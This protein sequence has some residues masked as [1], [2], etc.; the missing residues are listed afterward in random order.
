EDQVG[1][2]SGDQKPPATGRW[3]RAT[4]CG[5]RA[6][7]RQMADVRD[8]RNPYV[9]DDHRQSVDAGDD[10][11]GESERRV[12]GGIWSPVT[13]RETLTQSRSSGSRQGE[14]N[15]EF[16]PVNAGP[17]NGNRLGELAGRRR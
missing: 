11:V 16:Q 3:P 17:Y 6:D 5:A 12:E 1:A 7:R 14:T 2:D 8:H 9:A 10:G 4:G 13:H 15:S